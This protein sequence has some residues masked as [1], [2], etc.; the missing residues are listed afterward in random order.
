MKKILLFS[1]LIIYFTGSFAQ[2]TDDTTSNTTTT[3]SDIIIDYIILSGGIGAGGVIS[4]NI[5]NSGALASSNFD[6]LFQIKH[7]RIG[8]GSTSELFITPEN[9]GRLTFG[10]SANVSKAYIMYEWAVFRR[11]P[12]NL[13]FSAQAGGF[14]RGDERD[15]GESEENR[16]F[17]NLGVMLELGSPTFQFYVRPMVEY[18]SYGKLNFHKELSA[19]G[20]FGF[21]WKIPTEDEKKRLQDRKKNKN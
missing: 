13:G 16:T 19:V 3:E 4:T 11:S 15:A 5:V 12:V 6:L 10:E 7:H 2:K 1:F 20:Q 21:R 14:L 17:A 18:K 8:F 9:L